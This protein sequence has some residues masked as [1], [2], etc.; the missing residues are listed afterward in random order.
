M[1]ME[2]IQIKKFSLEQMVDNPSILIIAK[3]GTGKSVLVWNIIEYLNNK[4]NAKL[5]I[6]SPSEKMNPL[7]RSKYPDAVIE[8]QYSESLL[9]T[10]LDDSSENIINKTDRQ[11][12]MVM[13]DG[14]WAIKNWSDNYNL[15]E[16]LLNGRNYKIPRVISCQYPPKVKP[17]FRFNFDYIFFLKEDS[18]LTR[19]KLWDQYAGMFPR[20]AD[21]NKVFSELTSNYC[22]MV[23]DNIK[24]ADRID[25]KIH[26]FRANMNDEIVVSDDATDVTDDESDVT[27]DESDDATDVTDDE[28]D[29][30]N[31]LYTTSDDDTVATEVPYM[32]LN[33]ENQLLNNSN[34]DYFR[35]NYH[36]D[37]YNFT[38]STD[39]LR[40]NCDTMKIIYDHIISLK[41]NKNEYM[42]L[43]NDNMRLQLELKSYSAQP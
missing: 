1:E 3:K 34:K 26:W 38:L 16:M 5:T 39:K 11:N 6:I 19:K 17:V 43:L 13:D 7:Y 30:S 23:I 28:S 33:D 12:I 29:D 40:D 32:S 21:F 14:L 31:D 27:D 25:E 36:D 24:A 15:T 8:Y 4:Y 42:C 37:N 2:K 18:L 35:I 22:A 10:I 9:K 20:F 41:N